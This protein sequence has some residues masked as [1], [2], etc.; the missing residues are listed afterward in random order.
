MEKVLDQTKPKAIALSKTFCSQLALDPRNIKTVQK[1]C[2]ELCAKLT[3]RLDGNGKE[4]S[5]TPNLLV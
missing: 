4:H 2:L 3:E 1:S 5:R